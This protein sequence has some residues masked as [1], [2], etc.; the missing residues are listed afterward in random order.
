M[1]GHQPVQLP[2]GP[3][4]RAGRGALVAGNTVVLKPSPQGSFTGYKL[5]ECLRDAGVP[6]G[7]SFLPGGDEVGK[8][9]VAHDSVDSITFTGSFEVGMKIHKEF[10]KGVPRPTV[11]EMGGKNPAIVSAKADLDLAAEGVLHSAFGF[12]RRSARPARGCT[13]NGRWPG[14]SPAGWPTG[15]PSCGSATRWTARPTWAR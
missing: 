9:V 14:S 15:R 10:S 3:G 12:S 2:H 5:Y 11:C 13:W 4:R 1:G 7:C 6:A 8:L